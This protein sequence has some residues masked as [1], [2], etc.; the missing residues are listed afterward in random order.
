M[1]HNRVKLCLQDYP[2]GKV[3]GSSSSRGQYNDYTAV[4][5]AQIGK[6]AA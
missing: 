2:K 3:S 6:Y 1:R 5:Q 4:Q